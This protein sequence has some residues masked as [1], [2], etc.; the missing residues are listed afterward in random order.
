MR[1]AAVLAAVFAFQAAPSAAQG[2]E[3]SFR[4]GV[5]AVRAGDPE[6]AVE[7]FEAA[8]AAGLATGALHFNLGV[9]YYRAGR[10]VDAETSFRRAVDSGT[11]VAPAFYQLGRL[12]RERGDRAQARD[13]FRRAAGAA[14]TPALRRH[15]RAALEGLARTPPPDYVYV[16]IGGGHD[17]NLALTPSDASGVSEE[18]DA[19]LEGVLVARVPLD[20]RHYFR[21]S[22][23]LQEFLSEDDFS[24]VS[25]RGGIGRV[26]LLD[27]GWRWDLWLDG[28][29]REFGGRAFDNAALGGGELRRPLGPGWRVELDYRL[30][31][32]DG[33]GG[34]GFLDGVGHELAARLDERGRAGWRLDASLA[35]S[36][37]DDRETADDFFSFS[38]TELRLA[39]R[40]GLRLGTGDLLTLA[41]DWGMRDY[42]GTEVRDGM[43]LGTREDDLAGLEA[44]LD[45]R[46]DANWSLRLAL[47]LEQRDSS[48]AEFDYDRQIVTATFERVF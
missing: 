29:H 16:G 30:D 4:R 38:W 10:P 6:R 7:H 13:Y 35:T 9:A 46:L 37:R 17:S 40:Y 15:A 36:D 3:E 11:M 23:Y 44:A 22:V 47:R 24:L 18:S 8:R 33:A 2:P 5:A 42:D 45:R 28:R 25:L 20:E 32:V 1:A 14:R 26:G 41:G 48:L 21:G 39:A 27:G 43:R 34:F 31:L 12:A 19:F